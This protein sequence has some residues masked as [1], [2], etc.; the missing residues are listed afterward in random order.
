MLP[1]TS[2]AAKPSTTVSAPAEASSERP[3][4]SSVLIELSTT[5]VPISTAM[6]MSA[7]RAAVM[8]VAIARMW[9]FSGSASSL[10]LFWL[11]LSKTSSMI[12][13]RARATENT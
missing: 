9:E 5:P 12:S 3:S 6:T 2:R 11:I 8:V 13:T 1:S 10:G 4:V 7:L